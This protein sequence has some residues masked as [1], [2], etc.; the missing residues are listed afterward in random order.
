VFNY[1]YVAGPVPGPA[2]TPG[3]MNAFFNGT[4]GPQFGVIATVPEPATMAL[5]GLGGLAMLMFRRRK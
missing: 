5:A 2:G 1:S 4:S 3:N